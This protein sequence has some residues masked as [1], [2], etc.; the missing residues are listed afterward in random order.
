MLTFTNVSFQYIRG[1]PVVKDWTATAEGGTVT[2]VAGPN[3]SGKTTLLK[4][5]A[6]L[7]APDR[8]EITGR[9]KILYVPTSVEFHETLTLSEQI[10]YLTSAGSLDRDRLRESLDYWGFADLSGDQA[11]GELSTG[12]RQRL[13]FALADAAAGR[14]VLLDEPFANLDTDGAERL[15][16]W[17]T[18]LTASGCAVLA[19]QHGPQRL[20]DSVPVRV[21]ALDGKA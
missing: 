8:G 15:G 16:E 10:A 4:L 12:W 14:V 9:G 2:L 21:L 7:L 13:A 20:P 5:G 6:G 17:L 3:G 18:G 1:I 19:A 11:V